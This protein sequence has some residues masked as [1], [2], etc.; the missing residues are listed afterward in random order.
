MFSGQHNKAL[1]AAALAGLCQEAAL[2]YFNVQIGGEW[3]V[4]LVAVISAGLTGIPTWLTRNKVTPV[5]AKE[6]LATVGVT[7]TMAAMGV[8][9]GGM[10]I[11]GSQATGAY[12][13]AVPNP[14]AAP[15]HNWYAQ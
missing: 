2:H 13:V 15:S 4:L 12:N 10:P 9:T 14:G 8:G 6:V 1:I 5:Q 11:D 3:Q 7:P